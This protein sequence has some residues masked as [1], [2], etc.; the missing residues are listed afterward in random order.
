MTIADEITPANS[1]PIWLKAAAAL[2]VVWYAFGL[3]QMCLG[4]TLDTASAVEL[5]AITSD[6]REA[7]DATP[8]IIWL[9]FALA[10]GAG[11]VG[12]VL[13]FA[14]SR[15]AFKIFT[16]SLASAAVYYI[17]VYGLSGTGSARPSEEAGIAVFV[18]AVTLGFTWLATRRA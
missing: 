10:S 12:A 13:L 18:V 8:M 7:I 5:G 14:G 4:F 2:G 11:L 16:L 1:T 3:L 15:N 17:W 6:H 9:S